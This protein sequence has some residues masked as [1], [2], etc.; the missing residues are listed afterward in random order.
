MTSSETVASDGQ[1]ESEKSATGD[2]ASPVAINQHELPK[3]PIPPPDV[4]VR[5][6][7]QILGGFFT[8]FN[9][10][11]ITLSYGTF[12]SYVS[13]VLLSSLQMLTQLV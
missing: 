8:M 3:Q 7:L 9:A 6:H 5:A 1:V 10:W 12:Q 2:N 11:G 4:G 13:P